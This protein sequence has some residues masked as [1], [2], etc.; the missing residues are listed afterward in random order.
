MFFKS[1]DDKANDKN[2]KK[3]NQAGPIGDHLTDFAT[4]LLAGGS[5][6]DLTP[7]SWTNP[8][9][10]KQPNDKNKKNRGK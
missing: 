5:K 2:K 6:N 1:P 9:K 3:S 8:P 10:N 7:S 4:D